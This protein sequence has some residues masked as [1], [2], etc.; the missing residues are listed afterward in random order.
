VFC[1]LP[2]LRADALRTAIVNGALFGLC[3]YATYDLTNQ[4]TLRIWS[5]LITVVDLA[6]GVTVTAAGATGG[7]F[8]T[9]LFLTRAVGASQQSGT[10]R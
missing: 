2:A 6:W 1:V 7:F 3:A 4:A 9:R 8:I 10:G 5:T